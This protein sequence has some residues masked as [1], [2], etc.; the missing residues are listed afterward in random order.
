MNIEKKKLNKKKVL[1]LLNIILFLIIIISSLIKNNDEYKEITVLLNN[2]LIQLKDD[3][4][5]ENKN[6]YFSKDD[7]E[8]L[9]DKNI[10][11]NEAQKEFITVFNT[12]VAYMKLNESVCEIN[13]QSISINGKLQE[14]N[15]KIYIPISDLGIV[16]DL[17]VEYSEKTNRVILDSTNLKK[18]EATVLKRTNLQNKKGLFSSKIEKLIIGDKVVVIEELGKY[19]KIRTVSGNIGYVKSKMLSDNIVIRQNLE[20]SKKDIKL[21]DGYANMSGVYEDFLVDET[22]LNVIN[23]TMFYIDDDFRVLD[24]SSTNTAT[25]SVYKTW[26]DRNKLEILP[27]LD[28]NKS[29]SDTLFKYSRKKS[30]YYIIN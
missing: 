23:P 8:N 19:K 7:I 6:I 20:Y 14:I 11:Y 27:V 24:K 28:N 18:V 26:A 16:Y 3:V 21:Y 5:V 22:K 30:N 12:H 10:Y 1:C 15:G 25:Y 29:V 2:E 17:D 13:G 9:F 4:K